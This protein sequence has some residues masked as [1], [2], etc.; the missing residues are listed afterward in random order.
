[1]AA[2][3]SFEQP[4]VTASAAGDDYVVLAS[5]TGGVTLIDDAGHHELVRS[6]RADDVAA[7]R[8]VYTL[9][10]STVTAY[11]RSGTELWTKSGI[12][13]PVAITADPTVS[14]LYVRTAAE[15][16]VT[17]A[18]DGSRL[19][20]RAVPHADAPDEPK[21]SAFGGRVVVGNWSSVSVWTADESSDSFKQGDS[22]EGRVTGAISAVGLVGETA[23]IAL[24]DGSVHGYADGESQWDHDWGV[25]WLAPVGTSRLLCRTPEGIAAIDADGGRR[26]VTGVPT[27]GS[28]VV[29]ADGRLLCHV[30]DETARVFHAA[31]DPTAGVEMHVVGD[32]LSPHARE[33]RVEITNTGESL[34]EVTAT[35]RGEGLTLADREVAVSLPPGES[36][37][38]ALGVRSIDGETATVTL[39]DDETTL[40]SA[41]VPVVEPDRTATVEAEPIESDGETV[42]LGVT[43]TNDGDSPLA[44]GSVAGVE[45][46][47]LTP[48]ESV[49]VE[50]RVTP[51][52][53]RVRVT[54]EGADDRTVAVSVPSRLVE[55]SVT[56]GPEG[57]VDC[58]V[59]NRLSCP[60]HDR[61]SVTG[62][63]APGRTVSREVEVAGNGRVVWT[64]PSVAGGEREITARTSSDSVSR[65]FDPGLVD[66]VATARREAERSGG[67]ESGQAASGRATGSRQ[68]AGRTTDDRT[69]GERNGRPT[70]GASG[71]PTDGRR[72]ER[73]ASGESVGNERRTDVERA[74]GGRVDE[75]AV[76]DERIDDERNTQTDGESRPEETAE[77]SQPVVDARD[78]G[79]EPER[80]NEFGHASSESERDDPPL[81]NPDITVE[82]RVETSAPD[83][84]A[85]FRERIRVENDG[86]VPRD[87]TI[88]ADPGELQVGVTAPPGDAAVGERHL[89]AY[90]SGELPPVQVTANETTV[91]SDPTQITVTEP[92]ITPYVWWRVSDGTP[93]LAVA[94]A[95]AAGHTGRL[96]SVE[97]GGREFSASSP[98]EGPTVVRTVIDLPTEPPPG[99]APVTLRGVIDGEPR[100]I[101]TLVSH[102]PDEPV[103]DPVEKLTA[104][105]SSDS[106]LANGAGTLYLEVTND[107]DRAVSEL[108]LSAAGDGLETNWYD[109]E[110]V[111][112][113]PGERADHRL[114]IA[115]DSA[116][117]LTVTLTIGD[118]EAGTVTLSGPADPDRDTQPADVI[119]CVGPSGESLPSFPQ[120]LAEDV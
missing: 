60:L 81:E 36:R 11:E 70:D 7:G 18:A 10:A 91:T 13:E 76:G 1:M 56:E 52:T 5:S 20:R 34:V 117:D 72:T 94:L 98:F 101:E 100:V 58:A 67:T 73:Q 71:R 50:P 82:R 24:K 83:A 96:N 54:I 85:T 43:V 22:F 97:L 90:E 37:S 53:D 38:V 88:E 107:G 66:A 74:S 87:V 31:G 65:S 105:L 95:V 14:R 9:T 33:L 47:R 84:G 42:T 61:L 104:E 111:T 12:D 19:D 27:E 102:R 17:L 64:L 45:F 86:T 113:E 119:D 80:A 59:Q 68:T 63:P 28:H 44:G 26:G 109:P 25:D 115:A 110:T 6:E 15:E 3:T 106:S 118:R 78:A 79:D 57:F 103:I 30:A 48:G 29:S 89:V 32:S 2:A 75:D 49:T 55:V 23:V 120:F 112:L 4:G 93:R 35:P 16:L 77:A 116:L 21:L 41:S 39:A 69:D 46:G 8:N 51:P 114:P 108:T 92:P 99:T 62:V 40:A